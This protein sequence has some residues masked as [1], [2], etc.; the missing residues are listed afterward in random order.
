MRRKNVGIV[1]YEEVEV[2]DFC[3]PFEVFSVTR[4]NEER[5]RDEL[6]PFLPLL[7]AES[8][9]PVTA[10]GGMQVLPHHSMSDCPPLD[11]VVVPGGRHR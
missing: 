11:V 10:T 8:S 2:L 4:V 7:I 3:G 9:S 5:R 1:I 6:S